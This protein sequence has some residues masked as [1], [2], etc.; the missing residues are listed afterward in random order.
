MNRLVQVQ[1]YILFSQILAEACGTE[2]TERLMLP[3][4]LTMANDSVANVRFNVAKTLTLVGPKLN[5]TAMTSQ[6]HLVCLLR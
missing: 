2:I 5:T 6:V 1:H 3:T 4:V